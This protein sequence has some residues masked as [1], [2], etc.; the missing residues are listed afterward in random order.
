MARPDAIVIEGRAYSWRALVAQRKAQL[1][2]WRKTQGEQPALFELV[3]D[4]RPAAES[5]AAGRYQE[6]SL[7]CWLDDSGQ[8][9]RDRSSDQP[10][11]YPSCWP[12]HLPTL[13]ISPARCPP[14]PTATLSRSVLV[15]ARA[16]AASK[17]DF[18]A[19]MRRSAAMRCQPRRRRRCVNSPAAPLSPA[20]R[21]A[22]ELSA[23]AAPAAATETGWSRSVSSA[24]GTSPRNLCG[25][26]WPVTGFDSQAVITGSLP[27]AQSARRGES[28]QMG[29]PQRVR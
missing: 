21:S 16:S 2:A 4:C 10:S 25:R 1:E 17:S 28:R 3:H 9:R 24:A 27:A 6:P 11:P 20:G 19:S 29:S 12:R 18:A 26:A 5:S 23:M 7:L 22:R 14:S 8:D 13:P 15:W